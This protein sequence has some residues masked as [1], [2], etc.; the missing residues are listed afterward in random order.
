MGEGVPA[1]RRCSRGACSYFYFTRRAAR[2]PQFRG[3]ATGE[4]VVG[5]VFISYSHDSPE[6][7]ERVLALANRLRAMGST[8]RS[9]AIMSARR[10]AGRIGANS[11]SGRKCRAS[12]SSSVRR[13]TGRAWEIAQ[14]RKKAAASIGKGRSSV[15]TSTTPKPMRASFQCCWTTTPCRACRCRSTGISA[16]A[17]GRSSFPIPA[18]LTAQPEITKPALGDLVRLDARTAIHVA[19]ALPPKR[20]VTEFPSLAWRM[21]ARE[22]SNSLSEKLKTCKCTC[23]SFPH[24]RA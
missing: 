1:R 5:K 15:T 12:C 16:I 22:I 7:S 24:A 19:G 8:P 6:H 4:A 10:T 17:C 20:A 11:S 14:A 2:I 13:S 9:T 21:G 18:E 23:T 3:Q